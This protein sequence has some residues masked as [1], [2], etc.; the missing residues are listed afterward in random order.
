MLVNLPGISAS[1]KL[2]KKNKK[3]KKKQ[4][5]K[6]KNTEHYTLPIKEI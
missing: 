3:K 2:K 1:F 6:K 4:K 5:K